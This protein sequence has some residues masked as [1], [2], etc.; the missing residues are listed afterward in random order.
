MSTKFRWLLVGLVLMVAV[1][2]IASA[3]ERNKTFT[4]ADITSMDIHTV[5][6]DLK[7]CP[8]NNNQLVVELKND[9][10][11]P[12]FFDPKVESDQGDLS[13]EDHFTCNHVNGEIHWT[14][15]LPKSAELRIIKCH[16]ASGNMSFV[17]FK[18]ESIR[19]ESASGNVLVDLVSGKE[20]EFSTASG[21]IMVKDCSAEFTKVSSASGDISLSSIQ[22]KELKLSTASG[23]ITLKGCSADTPKI[24]SVSGCISISGIRSKELDISN[25]SGSILVEESKI[26][27]NGK[28]TSASGDIE[29]DLS[30]LPS[31]GL[32]ASTA[33]S[34][35]ILKVPDF[36][37]N[38]SM[39]LVKRENMGR[40]RCPFEYTG[41]S[42]YR[43]IGRAD[44][45]MER[46]TVVRGKDGP[47]IS[48]RSSSGA[49][50]IETATK[51][52]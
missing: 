39:T 51:G 13:I 49:I 44:Y 4:F 50:I 43:D 46:Y 42:T 35:L 37:E 16:S 40:I 45:L 25:A 48:L 26:G 38:F 21:S 22:S 28:I 36:G 8:G 17:G 31:T 23:S 47:D 18:T 5:C 7:I 12:D 52:K 33:S 10:D 14:V 32:E 24:R 15:Y 1:I 19:T 9:L 29:L 20:F 41:K 34:D 11:N 30:Q 6:G 3:T 27:E 2:G